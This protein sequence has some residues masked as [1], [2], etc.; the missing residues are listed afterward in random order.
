MAD[1]SSSSSSLSSPLTFEMF[2]PIAEISS[3]HPHPLLDSFVKCIKVSPDG[4]HL[5]ASTED[6]RIEVYEVNEKIIEKY[7]YYPS[8]QNGEERLEIN[9]DETL[10]RRKQIKPGESVYDIQWFPY[11]H[12]ANP[13]SSCFITTCRDK[14]IQLFGS[15]NALLRGSYCVM[16]S[17]R[18]LNIH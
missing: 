10:S 17:A 16:N 1:T 6:N 2:Q 13:A 18:F 9:N 7:A 15:D 3:L 4:S 5:L 8:L 12:K 14:P 11:S